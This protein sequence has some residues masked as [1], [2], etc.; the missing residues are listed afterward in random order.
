MARFLVS[1]GFT[2]QAPSYLDSYAYQAPKGRRSTRK[3]WFLFQ[4]FWLPVPPAPLVINIWQVWLRGVMSR[5]LEN[6]NLLELLVIVFMR[7][8]PLALSLPLVPSRLSALFGLLYQLLCAAVAGPSAFATAQHLHIPT[9][10]KT[11]MGKACFSS[12]F[13]GSTWRPPLTF[14]WSSEAL[15]IFSRREKTLL[16][17]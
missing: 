8:L 13:L 9:M 2:G 4:T 5:D 7:L 15:E 14:Y 6:T 17:T 16:V 3:D 12:F 11:A 1:E 10:A